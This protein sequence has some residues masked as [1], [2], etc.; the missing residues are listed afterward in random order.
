M[1]VLCQNW[2]RLFL[3][4]DQSAVLFA[5]SFMVKKVPNYRVSSRVRLILR[6]AT[7]HPLDGQQ[8]QGDMVPP[9]G[10]DT[11]GDDGAL[12][13]ILVLRYHYREGRVENAD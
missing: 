6:M 11:K 3:R 10:S 12:S 5:S 1:P 7:S 9:T 8:L 13:K 4:L 2:K